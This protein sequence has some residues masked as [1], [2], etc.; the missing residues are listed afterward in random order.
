MNKSAIDVVSVLSNK[1]KERFH[2]PIS[3]N[4]SSINA[5]R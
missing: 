5:E 4:H 1:A 3:M 2:W